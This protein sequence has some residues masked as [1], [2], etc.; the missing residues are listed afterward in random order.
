MQ[1]RTWFPSRMSAPDV[2]ARARV[3][4]PVLSDIPWLG[5]VL[6]NQSPIVYALYLL[7][8]L[9]IWCWRAP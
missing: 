5:V 9:T 6:F 2:G 4:V 1:R 8:P 3:K 7:V